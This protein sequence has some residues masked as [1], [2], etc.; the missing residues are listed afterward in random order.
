MR[1]H[2]AGDEN[3]FIGANRLLQHRDPNRWPQLAGDGFEFYRSSG[4]DGIQI[5]DVVAHTL[6]RA[7]RAQQPPPGA[8]VPVYEY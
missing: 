8:V 4:A 5:A 6:Y 7:N 1:F 2:I 3:A